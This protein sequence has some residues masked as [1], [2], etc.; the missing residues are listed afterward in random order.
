[1]TATTLSWTGAHSDPDVAPLFSDRATDLW[2]IHGARPVTRDRLLMIARGRLEILLRAQP[3][4]ETSV[5]RPSVATMN[6][7]LNA[8]IA[9]EQPTPQLFAAGDGAVT[10]EWLV[11]GCHLMVTAE[12]DGTVYWCS[13]P[14]DGMAAAELESPATDVAAEEM[15]R[16][17]RTRLNALAKNVSRR[18]PVVGSHK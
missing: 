4:D 18:H 17:F 11:G 16:E 10:C 1:M 8:V 13:D 2:I 12:A 9:D 7:I 15:A 14:V 3:P 5:A 6:A